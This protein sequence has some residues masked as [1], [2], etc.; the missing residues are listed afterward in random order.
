M[1]VI[2]LQQKYDNQ[3]MEKPIIAELS[4]S[5]FGR[6]LRTAIAHEP[7]SRSPTAIALEFNRR[8]PHLAVTGH[9]VRKWLMG[10]AIPTQDKL[11]ALAEWLDVD[12]A[13]LRFGA[14]SVPSIS[15]PTREFSDGIERDIGLLTDDERKVIRVAINAI[16]STRKLRG[17]LPA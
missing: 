17:I 13:W 12:P 14:A 16:F 11:V 2:Y 7:Y 4:R 9:A 3:I 6:R 1:I 8:F 5:E 10:E 15:G